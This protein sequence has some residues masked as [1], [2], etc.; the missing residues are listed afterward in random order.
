MAEM[1]KGTKLILG[2]VGITPEML[3]NPTAILRHFGINPDDV[4]NKVA[5][6]QQIGL[7]LERSFVEVNIRLARI[8][9]HLGIAADDTGNSGGA[10][11][12]AGGKLGDMGQRP[13][14]RR[15]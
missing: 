8:E 4:T 14:N 11:D 9:A 7:R 12:S 3:N 1:S 13:V 5:E 10:D 15:N 2:M 6:F